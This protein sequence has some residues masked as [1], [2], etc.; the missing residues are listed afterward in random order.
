MRYGT[1]WPVYARQWD[2]MKI[3]PPRVKEFEK[4]A[5]KFIANK[6][7]YEL[8]EKAT[9]VPWHMIAL[10]H[11]RESGGNFNTYLGNGDPLFDKSG[12]PIKST[13]VPKARGPFTTKKKSVNGA[14][15]EAFFYGA[16]DALKYEG[17]AGTHP[18]DYWRLEKELYFSELYNGTGY[19][20][21]GLPSAYIWGG[22]NIQQRGKYIAD[23]KWDGTVMDTQPG[24]AP[25]LKTLMTLDPTIKFIRED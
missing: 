8:I 12:N 17:F 24:V 14:T 18:T 6:A 21:K 25:L 1:K 20:D 9:G 13:H 22:T 15:E 16:I 5:K 11:E 2:T 4:L 3:N 23:S 7:R 19:N 10:L